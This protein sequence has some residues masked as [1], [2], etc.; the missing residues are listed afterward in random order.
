MAEKSA[1]VGSSEQRVTWLVCW[2]R[3]DGALQQRGHTRRRGSP[4][5]ARPLLF[6]WGGVTSIFHAFEK[7]QEGGGSG[8]F[9][10]TQ[11]LAPQ[12][13][14]EGFPSLLFALFSSPFLF[15][16]FPFPFLSFPTL[17]RYSLLFFHSRKKRPRL[18]QDGA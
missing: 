7:G 10:D 5:L 11:K 1:R 15:F 18:K 14:A 16:P 4:T 3:R 17:L 13:K 2:S 9:S 6:S 12:K 8:L